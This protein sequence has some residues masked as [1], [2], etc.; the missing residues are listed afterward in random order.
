MALALR[1]VRV[2]AG[3]AGDGMLVFHDGWLVAVLVRLSNLH[4]HLA[5]HWFLE[6]GFGELGTCGNPHFPD[7]DGATEWIAECIGGKRD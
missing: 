4:E 7:L 2:A 3:E 5:G 6:I 1:R